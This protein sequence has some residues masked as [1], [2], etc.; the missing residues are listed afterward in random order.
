MPAYFL[1]YHNLENNAIFSIIKYIILHSAP[2]YI[3]KFINSVPL[4]FHHRGGIL[5]VVR[6]DTND[7]GAPDSHEKRSQTTDFPDCSD[8]IN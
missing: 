6:G 7:L 3:L 4:Y 8:F 5:R 2:Y 1:C